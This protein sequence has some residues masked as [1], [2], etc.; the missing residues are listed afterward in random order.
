M[1]KWIP[2]RKVW[3]G[4][5]TMIVAWLIVQALNVYAGAA[6]PIGADAVLSFAIGKGVEFFVPPST[7]DLIT[8]LDNEIVAYAGRSSASEVSASVGAAAGQAVVD[9]LTGPAANDFDAMM[10]RITG[11]S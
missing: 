10:T 8:K 11:P 6:I 7:R 3:A 1:S 4:G 2:D 9:K 5:V